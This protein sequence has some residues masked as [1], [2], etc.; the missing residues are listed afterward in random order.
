MQ[1]L[2][3]LQENVREIRREFSTFSETLF[4]S[5]KLMLPTHFV[6]LIVEFSRCVCHC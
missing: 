6:L 1:V 5:K 4:S 2:P 3:D